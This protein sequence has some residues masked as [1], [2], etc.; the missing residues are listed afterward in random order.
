MKKQYWK[1]VIASI[2]REIISHMVHEAVQ[3]KTLGDLAVRFEHFAE[4]QKAYYLHCFEAYNISGQGGLNCNE[5]V[6]CL[7]EILPSDANSPVRKR[8]SVAATLDE[9]LDQAQNEIEQI[10]S[11]AEEWFRIFGVQSDGHLG[12]EAFQALVVCITQ[13]SHGMLAEKDILQV[14]IRHAGID[15]KAWEETSCGSVELETLLHSITEVKP[16]KHAGT[17]ILEEI[18]RSEGTTLKREG[19]GWKSVVH[20]MKKELPVSLNAVA[21]YVVRLDVQAQASTGRLRRAIQ[22]ERKRKTF[23]R[24]DTITGAVRDS[25]RSASLSASGSSP[26]KDARRLTLH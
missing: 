22:Y 15:K 4:G 6:K 26:E 19:K 20:H 23:G 21:K 18:R 2:K 3:S 25:A 9:E 17:I 13:S 14:L 1:V 16:F 24:R 10:T 12:L 8:M 11:D 5:L 7:T